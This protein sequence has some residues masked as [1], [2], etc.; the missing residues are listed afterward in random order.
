MKATF[1]VVLGSLGRPSLKTLLD[2]VA[3]QRR[4]PGDQCI[5]SIDAFEQGERPDVQ[6]LVRSYGE[7]FVAC[8]YD[9]GYHYLG[10]E[11]INYAMRSIWLTGTHMLM[12]GDDDVFADG[13]FEAIRPF[14]SK[15]LLRPVLWRVLSP[16]S[17]SAPYDRELFPVMQY[18]YGRIGGSSI[19]APMPH[20][21]PLTTEQTLWHDN[22]W[23]TDVI[24]N[25]GVEPLWLDYT[26]VI[27][28][29][30]PR[31]DDV[32]HRGVWRCWHCERWRFLEDVSPTE[33]HCECGAVLDLHANQPK[34][35]N[36]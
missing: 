6:A 31:G 20:V 33:T 34:A 11:Q 19:A 2:S 29:P 24:H 10:I 15:D 32:T 14:C 27:T 30:E 5:V 35:V 23:L 26:P 7:G 21:R 18:E 28:R 25:S 16:K 36:L 9:S 3:R 4:L 13:A 1:T 12:I 22:W 8:A 17:L